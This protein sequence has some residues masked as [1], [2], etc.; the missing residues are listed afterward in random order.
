MTG[1]KIGANT[2]VATYVGGPLAGQ[3]VTAPG[4]RHPIYRSDKGTPLNPAYGDW[5]SW[6]PGGHTIHLRVLHYAHREIIDDHIVRHFY[7]HATVLP[8]WENERRAKPHRS[9]RRPAT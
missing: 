2:V 6:S 3:S 8:Q 1:Q 7:I 5:I 9:P 4:T